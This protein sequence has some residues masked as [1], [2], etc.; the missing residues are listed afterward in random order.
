[1]NKYKIKSLQKNDRK[2]SIVNKHVSSVKVSN[3]KS[4]ETKNK[5]LKRHYI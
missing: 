1:M 3:T 2:S 4:K 5:R